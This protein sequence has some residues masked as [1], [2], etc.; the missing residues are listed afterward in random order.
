MGRDDSKRPI[1]VPN[2]NAKHI[3]KAFELLSTGVY[4]QK[5]VLG[6]LCREDFK[7]SSTAIARI[8]RNPLYHGDIHIA[9]FGEEQENV[10]QGIHEPLITKSLFNKVQ[11][12]IDGKKK[13]SG[14]S[15]KKINE[16]FPL[17]G[18]VLCPKCGNPLLGQHFQR[19]FQ[20][21]LLLSLCQTLFYAL[22]S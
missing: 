13:Q 12:I 17:K 20:F 10:V 1:L 22:Q 4:N 16:K 8:I 5:E 21:L 18:F 3:Q 14:T 9:A 2:G 15:H 11:E 19:S 7:S 6:Q